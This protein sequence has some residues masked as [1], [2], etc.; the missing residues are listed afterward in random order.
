VRTVAHV[1]DL[2]VGRDARTDAATAALVRS[3]V[4]AEVDEV[5]LTG[6]VTHRGRG[7]EL[8][9]FERMFAP[10]SGRLTVVPG[11][12]DRMGDDVA[13]RLMPGPRVEAVARRGLF[14]VR[15]D[16]TAPHNRSAVRSHGL[17][18][19]EDV[20][21]VL[22]AVDAAP[23]C[24]LVVL[25]LHHHLHRLPEDHVGERLATLLGWPNAAELGL[26]RELLDRLQGRCDVV[27]HGHRH[28]ASELVLF[29]RC[30]RAIHVLNAGSTPALGRARVIAHEAGSL[31]SEHWL[32]LA[33]APRTSPAFAPVPAGA[34]A[35]A[36]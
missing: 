31:A 35:A 28:A 20:D 24:A 14:V 17:L 21:A 33:P 32:D 23:R 7:A 12:H 29:P 15:L 1:S 34:T 18:T 36:A 5:L 16:S 27:M 4:D 19:R 8:D 3:L 13:S 2:H 26:G 6:D 30:G 11:N 10:L 22:R 25:M 9:S